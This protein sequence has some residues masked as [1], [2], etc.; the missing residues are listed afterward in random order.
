MKQKQLVELGVKGGALIQKTTVEML[1]E[2]AK[3]QMNAKETQDILIRQIGEASRYKI[4]Q[5][6]RSCVLR[7]EFDEEKKSKL[8][9][10]TT[11]YG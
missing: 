2:M 10:S 11:Y 6:K 8:A 9:A 4:T 3:A 1:D 7:L 5:R